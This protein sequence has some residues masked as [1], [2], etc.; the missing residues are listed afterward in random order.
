MLAVRGDGSVWGWGLNDR[1][2]VGN[3]TV[4]GDVL[5]PVQVTGL[6]LN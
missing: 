4:G 6:N 5:T 3:G 1:G 2:Q